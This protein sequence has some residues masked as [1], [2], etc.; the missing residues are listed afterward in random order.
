MRSSNKLTKLEL[1]KQ[2]TLESLPFINEFQ[3]TKL[4]LMSAV[5][6]EQSK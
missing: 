3:H 5:I 2:T 4:A 1:A 6:I